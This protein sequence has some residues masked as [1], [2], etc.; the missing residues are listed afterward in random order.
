MSTLA[1]EHT[2]PYLRLRSGKNFY[3][4]TPTVD[5]VEIEDIAHALGN[6]CRFGGHT[7][8]FYSVAQHSVLCSLMAPEGFK[9]AALLHDA[10]EAYLV[11]VPRPIKALLPE[12]R[13]IEHNLALCIEKKFELPED[14]MEHSVIKEVDSRM[15]VSE[16]AVLV[17]VDAQ[18]EWGYTL[19]PYQG[20]HIEGWDPVTARQYFMN[21]YEQLT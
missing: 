21:R 20:L 18:K 3:P 14:I 15:L 1:K 19:A 2:G 17:G 16:A 8:E 13:N 5:M 4:L 12:Y 9:L 11:D 7:R 6:L 10:T